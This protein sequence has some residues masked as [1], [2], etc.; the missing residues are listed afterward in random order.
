MEWANY[1]FRRAARIIPLF[2]LAVL[3]YLPFGYV[4]KSAGEAASHMLF[5]QGNGHL[6]TV[7][8]EV[9]FYVILPA[10]VASLV[11]SRR[12]AAP[13]ALSLCAVMWGFVVWLTSGFS[14]NT[15]LA[16][17]SSVFLSGSI[18]AL[19]AT[20]GPEV[21]RCTADV[22][23]YAA[24]SLIV[25]TTPTV[26]SLIAYPVDHD[27]FYDAH[28]FFG[29]VAAI[30]I[31]A[32]L[33]GDG[34]WRRIFSAKPLL[35]L[36][37]ISYSGYLIHPLILLLVS[38]HLGGPD[39]LKAIVAGSLSLAVGYVVYSLIERPLAALR[40]QVKREVPAIS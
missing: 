18:A 10:I 3:I 27:Y 23:G 34:V 9:K 38:R 35:F 5:L 25:L 16:T 21:S 6:W 39:V 36:G 26:W 2:W 28:A 8:V 20:D 22:A 15:H 4:V 24:C 11:A 31:C 7:V 32:S 14:E 30:I 17:Y 12:L 33:K 40:L 1:A 37:M 19:F 29:V 13:I